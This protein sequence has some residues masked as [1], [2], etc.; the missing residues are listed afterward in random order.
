MVDTRFR[1]YDM[2]EGGYG[3]EESGYNI[4]SGTALLLALLAMARER[5]AIVCAM[6]SQS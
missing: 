5:T 1:G 3:K 2:K 6:M 4:V